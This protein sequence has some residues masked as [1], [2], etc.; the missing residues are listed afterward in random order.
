MYHVTRRSIARGRSKI[1]NLT[2]GYTFGSSET[3]TNVKLGTLVSGGSVSNIVNADMAAG[4]AIAYSKLNLTGNIADGD[5][6]SMAAISY[7]KLALSAA[8]KNTDIASGFGI[9]PSGGI[10]MWSGTIATIPTGWFLCDGTNSTPNL[11]NRFV[12]CAD[13]DVSSVAKSTITGSALQTSE[14]QLIA[15]THSVGF[16]QAVQ[17]GSTTNCLTGAGSSVNI[18]TT[19]TGTGTAN[20]ARF[21]ALA[22]IM[23]S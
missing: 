10:I 1:A 11:T 5:I 4:A 9:V 3:V 16:T 2:A 20:V 22:F 7:S 19:S 6:S 17:S 14:G 21:Y 13:A 18:T 23:K 15:H 12:V 8:I